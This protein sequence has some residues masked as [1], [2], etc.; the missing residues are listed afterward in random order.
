MGNT[1]LES[2]GE[3]EVGDTDFRI[4]EQ[5]VDGLEV[6]ENRMEW[7]LSEEWMKI[8]KGW[9]VSHLKFMS[10]QNSRM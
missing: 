9:I 8:V 6:E 4:G 3:T 5:W 1:G 2:E 7:P 10:A